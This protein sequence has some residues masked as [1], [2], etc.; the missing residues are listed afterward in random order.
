MPLQP[1][2]LHVEVVGGHIGWGLIKTGDIHNDAP[3]RFENNAVFGTGQNPAKTLH[4]LRQW[5]DVFRGDRKWFQ[6]AILKTGTQC[7]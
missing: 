7:I 5:H 2:A 6:A 3:S 1:Q 4:G